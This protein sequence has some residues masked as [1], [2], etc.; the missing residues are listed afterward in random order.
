M[1]FIESIFEKVRR[2]P[3][4]IVF[5]EGTEERVIRAAVDFHS[6]GLGTAVLLGTKTAIQKKAQSLKVK[7]D[8][9]GLIDPAKADDL[10]HFVDR[11]ASLRKTK[12]IGKD[13]A[14]AAIKQPA[15]FATMM[16][17]NGSVDGLVAGASTTA[18]TMLRPLF[19]VIQLEPGVKA[20]SSCNVLQL[21]KKVF[22]Q[23]GVLYLADC[24]VI[25]DPTAEQLGDIALMAAKLARQLHGI[26]PRVAFLSYST[27]GSAR[28]RTL[29]K[30]MAAVALAQHKAAEKNLQADF[31]G[32]LQADSALVPAIANLKAAHSRVAGKANVLV[33]PDLNSGNI[34]SKLVQLVANG[35]VYG[36]I[37][38]GLCKPATDLSRGCT[39]QEIVGSAAIVALQSVEYRK[40]YPS[41][42]GSSETFQYKNI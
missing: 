19:Q 18:T 39:V 37:L 6:K 24:S 40:L 10:E 42:G 8:H 7:L 25:P 17:A 12:G 9:V 38:N 36:P 28:H 16:L 3:K 1:S 41:N 32:E 22:G 30:I 34:C 20:A 21:E 13:E 35:T 26:K 15:Y 5:P 11:F 23:D 27:K 33:F 29:E 4:R 31:D 2:H 14:I